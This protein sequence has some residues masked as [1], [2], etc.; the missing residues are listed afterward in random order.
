M[1]L[2]IHPLPILT[3]CAVLA[4][5]ASAKC[6][7]WLQFDMTG[8][9]A[10]T[11]IS[12]KVFDHDDKLCN[13]DASSDWSQ[14]VYNGE[15]TQ[16]RLFCDSD[17]KCGVMIYRYPGWDNDFIESFS[18]CD[19]N[20]NKACDYRRY[21]MRC[22]EHYIMHWAN[23]TICKAAMDGDGDPIEDDEGYWYCSGHEC[24]APDKRNVGYQHVE[25]DYRSSAEFGS[26]LKDVNQ[27]GQLVSIDWYMIG[28]KLYSNQIWDPE[29]TNSDWRYAHLLTSSEYQSTFDQ[30]KAD[31]YHPVHISSVTWNDGEMYYSAIFVKQ[32]S[33]LYARH[34][35]TNVEF[36][37]FQVEMLKLQSLVQPISVTMT[38]N[39]NGEPRYSA[40]FSNRPGLGG[41]RIYEV[42]DADYQDVFNYETLNGRYPSSFDART[43]PNGDVEYLVVFSEKNHEGSWP[44]RKQFH[45]MMS[46][47][48]LEDNHW[49]Y[50]DDHYEPQRVV[51]YQEGNNA[52]FIGSWIDY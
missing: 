26:G 18:K 8:G 47:S 6:E 22:D 4:T 10:S 7:F 11:G 5:T 44:N 12:S 32:T 49:E 52:K 45:H 33:L 39:A 51:G 24:T 20:S 38:T 30:N 42:S 15:R 3:L 35:M 41:Y 2:S 23:K 17:N 37:Q 9:G 27:A 46:Y 28:N 29:E 50:Y 13:Q 19:I 48:T 34:G 25:H 31:G 43:L 1:K 16:E 14:P 21:E 36:V 40:I